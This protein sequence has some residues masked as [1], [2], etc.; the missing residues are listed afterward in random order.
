M[1][2][3]ID[4][5]LYLK[6]ILY[7]KILKNDAIVGVG[8]LLTISLFGLYLL[9][10][11]YLKV[12]SNLDIES[13]AIPK[14]SHNNY[15]KV[16]EGSSFTLGGTVAFFALILLFRAKK[17]K[18]K[19]RFFKKVGIVAIVIF[20]IE[21]IFRLINF[22]LYLLIGLL[23]NTPAIIILMKNLKLKN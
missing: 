20:F 12:I 22:D 21:V 10:K 11:D 6:N 19:I 23:L 15:E 14:V 4:K 13:L 5:V 16:I 17:D 3:I 8:Y 1:L 2:T 7:V 18:S 9:V